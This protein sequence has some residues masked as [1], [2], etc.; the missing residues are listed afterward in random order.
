MMEL[1]TEFAVCTSPRR[2]P[3]AL[4]VSDY[5][6]IPDN[7]NSHL[8][9]TYTN[10]PLISDCKRSIDSDGHLT[11]CF[12]MYFS[13][14][15][16][17]ERLDPLTLKR[18]SVLLCLVT[19]NVIMKAENNVLKRNVE[20]AID[21]RKHLNSTKMIFYLNYEFLKVINILQA[22][23]ASAIVKSKD[24]STNWDEVRC[25]LLKQSYS[26]LKL[27]VSKLF[28]NNI[29]DNSFIDL[30][31]DSC[32]RIL[33][34]VTATLHKD[35]EDL[36]FHVLG[37]CFKKHMHTASYQSQILNIISQNENAVNSVVSGI[38]MLYSDYDL[39]SIFSSLVP[40]L[41]NMLNL[42]S[43]NATLTKNFSHFLVELGRKAPVIILPVFDSLQQGVMNVDPYYM[44]TTGLELSAFLIMDANVAAEDSLK[45]EMLNDMLE[46]V[47]DMNS[48]VRS[49]VF[50]LLHSINEKTHYVTQLLVKVLTLAETHLEDKSALVR[51][52]ALLLIVEMIRSNKSEKKLSIPVL[53]A[54]LKVENEKMESIM[55]V[56]YGLNTELNEVDAYLKK[57]IGNLLATVVEGEEEILEEVAEGNAD[58]MTGEKIKALMMA[59]YSSKEYAKLIQI[60][61]FV[62]VQNGDRE[63]IEKM[64]MPEREIL[65]KVKCLNMLLSACTPPEMQTEIDTIQEKKTE[66]E[67]MIKYVGI[68]SEC[69]E[70]T[71]RMLFSVTNSDVLA[72]IEFFKV[73]QI[74][75]NNKMCMFTY[76]PVSNRTNKNSLSF[77]LFP[78]WLRVQHGGC[79]I[80][81]ARNAN[82]VRKS[83]CECDADPDTGLC[84]SP[85]QE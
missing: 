50:Q 5:L 58:K 46:S 12:D 42:Q 23:K 37:L 28:E 66:T 68:I 32:Y 47:G 25:R 36:L 27:P 6:Y 59:A 34:A 69:V 4:T 57:E 79:R 49:K 39:K 38:V 30:F 77:I 53:E 7:R 9:C 22:A 71:K 55:A 33:S 85:V 60:V 1:L 62:F 35:V 84:G 14:I 48:Y 63:V 44:R 21:R 11:N 70:K 76:S 43:K 41:L 65:Y 17:G 81:F 20:D 61:H 54:E 83:G 8:L 45:L 73:S 2:S 51:K 3:N 18:T 56:L 31:T 13:I 78:G 16:H 10:I 75:F 24:T 72:A 67:T 15:K 40:E 82:I 26:F 74:K 64:S 19:E 52:N 29:M 80:R